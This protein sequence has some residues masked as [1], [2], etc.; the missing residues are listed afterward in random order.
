MC[1]LRF[2]PSG[3]CGRV[4]LLLTLASHNLACGGSP[5]GAQPADIQITKLTIVNARLEPGIPIYVDAQV[6]ESLNTVVPGALVVTAGVD[7]ERVA[8]RP[9]VCV[10]EGQP[11]VCGEVL[12]AVASGRRAQDYESIV[13]GLGGTLA[14]RPGPATSEWLGLV[15][16]SFGDEIRVRNALQRS[17]GIIDAQ[18]NFV[19]QQ[20]FVGNQSAVPGARAVASTTSTASRPGDGVL[21]I[22]PSERVRVTS[23]SDSSISAQ[24]IAAGIT[25]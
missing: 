11:A 7:S 23:A 2:P 25:P 3:T 13:R 18:L 6:S 17:D 4:V 16:V 5:T 1:A 15:L 14:T 9:G 12:F 10:I 20:R 22:I 8:L 24:A 19:M 21:Q